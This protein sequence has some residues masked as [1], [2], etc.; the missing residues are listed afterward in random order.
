M[1][2]YEQIITYFPE[3]E[4]TDTFAEGIILLQDDSDGNGAY[5]KEWNYNKSI[6][7]DLKQYVRG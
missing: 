3:L 6:P 5:I 7:N 4:G 1:T 2:L